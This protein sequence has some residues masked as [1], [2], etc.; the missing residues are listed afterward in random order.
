VF[1]GLNNQS[2][3]EEMTINNRER[4]SFA[5]VLLSKGLRPYVYRVMKTYH[6]DNWDKMVAEALPPLD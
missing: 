5:L 3:R 6:G 2:W 4:L 1:I